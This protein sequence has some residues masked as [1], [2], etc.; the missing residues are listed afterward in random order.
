MTVPAMPPIAMN[1]V[2]CQKIPHVINGWQ[3]KFQEYPPTDFCAYCTTSPSFPWCLDIS[4]KDV[5]NYPTDHDLKCIF[6]YA[7]S[8]N[9]F[10]P[11]ERPFVDLYFSSVNKSA[12]YFSD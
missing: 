6:T 9:E 11:T 3:A 1:R 5:R 8:S 12:R 7:L 2:S 4:I 10:P